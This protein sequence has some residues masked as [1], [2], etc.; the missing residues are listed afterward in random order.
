MNKHITLRIRGKD[1]KR[2]IR[3]LYKQNISFYNIEYLKNEAYI[4]IS[5][6]DYLKIKEIKTIYEIEIVKYH[7]LLKIKEIFL[8]YRMFLI[9]L[10]IGGLFLIFLS[11]IIFD[12]EVVYEKEDIR[13]FVL[14]ELKKYGIEKYRMVKPFYKNEEIVSNILKDNKDRI[15]WLEIENYGSKYIIK[16]EERKVKDNEILENPRNLVAK[17]KG[18]ILNIKASSGEVVKKINDY[19]NEGD[20]LISGTIM[21]K[22]KVK[23]YVAASGKVFAEVWYNVTVEIPNSYQEIKLTGDTKRNVKISFLNHDYYLFSKYSNFKEESIFSIGNKLLPI[24]FSILNTNE[25]IVTDEIYTEEK[26]ILKASSIAREKLLE[27]LGQ[28]DEIISEKS[29]K[30]YE[31]DSKIIVVIFFKVKEDI[32]SYQEIIPNELGE[33]ENK[34]N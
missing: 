31:E 18:M 11:H 4:R 23:G 6:S 32:T 2:F 24:S 34:T 10:F 26:A 9:F 29:L 12:V 15:E 8:F 30:I 25:T 17:K 28:E 13:N 3:N 22:D 1:V 19:V 16:L 21:N 33:E 20:I 7:G 27:S 14:N 5:Y